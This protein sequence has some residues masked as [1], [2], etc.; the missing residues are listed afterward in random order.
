MINP[1]IVL[2]FVLAVAQGSSED[3]LLTRFSGRWEG[4]GNR[5]RVAL[6]RCS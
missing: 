3:P 6:P 2:A 4:E 5:P 1:P